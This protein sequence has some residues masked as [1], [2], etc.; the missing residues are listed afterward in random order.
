ML[1]WLFASTFWNSVT[2]GL[3]SASLCWIARAASYD[4]SASPGLPVC[5][6]QSADVVVAH[7]Q[8]ALELGDGGVGVGQPLLDRPRR[9]DTTPAPLPA[10]RSLSARGR[11][12]CGYS[13]GRSG[14]W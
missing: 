4:A 8:V 13:P 11:C 5:S 3:A 14:T 6:Q 7:R 9:L 2:A 10:C 1:W 12:C